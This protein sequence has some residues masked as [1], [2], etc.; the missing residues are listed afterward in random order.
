[1]LRHDGDVHDLEEE[2]PS[3]M[4]LPIPT[5]D[6][7]LSTHTPNRVFARPT[8]AAAGSLLL[9]P[10]ATLTLL[11]FSTVGARSTRR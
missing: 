2:P 5:I 10:A 3:P 11:Y 4:I 9:K 1:M 8:S 6:P 7:S